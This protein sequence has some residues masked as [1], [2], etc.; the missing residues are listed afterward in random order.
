MTDTAYLTT[1]LAAIRAMTDTGFQ[2]DQLRDE[3]IKGRAALAT[4]DK[5]EG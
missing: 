3:L 1:T 2:F 4:P 5:G